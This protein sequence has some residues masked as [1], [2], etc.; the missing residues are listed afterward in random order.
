MH[1][2]LDDG[3]NH[4]LDLPGLDQAVRFRAQARQLGLV[5]LDAPLEVGDV[6][7]VEAFPAVEH[8]P[9]A[10]EGVALPLEVLEDAGV[11][12][13][14]LVLHQALRGAQVLARGDQPVVQERH[15]VGVGRVSVG[16]G[17]GQRRERERYARVVGRDAFGALDQTVQDVARV[18]V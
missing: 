11:P 7:L 13:L 3:L 2:Y 17:L 10:D 5:V 9:D 6:V 1:T 16:A 4:L 15:V 18:D 12:G 14:A 8:V